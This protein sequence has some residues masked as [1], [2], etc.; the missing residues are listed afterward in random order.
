MPQALL[1]CIGDFSRKTEF[2]PPVC[3]ERTD[4]KNRRMLRLFTGPGIN[5]KEND[6]QF[7]GE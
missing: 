4:R 6:Y 5:F 1:V 7:Q 3:Q 2:G